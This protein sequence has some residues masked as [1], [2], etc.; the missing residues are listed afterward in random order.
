[1][2]ILMENTSNER[3]GQSELVS[4]SNKGP[5]GLPLTP[6]IKV[7]TPSTLRHEIS[8]DNRVLIV[9]KSKV[10]NMTKYLKFHPGGDL[11]LLYQNGKDSTDVIDA[12]HPFIDMNKKIA[13]FY[14]G[15]YLA[16]DDSDDEDSGF[17]SMTSVLKDSPAFNQR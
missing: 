4:N 10:Y 9:Y 6:K 17:S 11:A 8:G 1:M 14:V 5:E 2:A 3:S 15:E 13:P 7:F 12:F 16:V